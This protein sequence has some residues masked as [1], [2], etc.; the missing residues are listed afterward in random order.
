MEYAAQRTKG[1]GEFQLEK[2][3]QLW[4]E[5]IIQKKKEK[6]CW[7]FT[8]LDLEEARNEIFHLLGEVNV[9][10]KLVH[11]IFNPVVSGLEVGCL[12]WRLSHHPRVQ[13]HSY[14]PEIHL[15]T[16]T[17]LVGERLWCNIVWSS[18]FSKK[19]TLYL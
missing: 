11:G 1:A 15:V 12:E 3:L 17:I 14:R 8:R 6:N 16:V 10:R 2:V 18:F 5:K 13:D 19:K 7:N 4:V 9:R